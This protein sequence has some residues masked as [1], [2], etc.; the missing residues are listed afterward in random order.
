MRGTV[1]G[2]QQRG[3]LGPHVTLVYLYTIRISRLSP[4]YVVLFVGAFFEDGGRVVF[5]KLV[6]CTDLYPVTERTGEL[7]PT[8]PSRHCLASLKYENRF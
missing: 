8:V 2:R 5:W 3:Q 1:R 7:H 4:V 6:S